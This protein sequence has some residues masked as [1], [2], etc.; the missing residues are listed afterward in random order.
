MDIHGEKVERTEVSLG[1][2]SAKGRGITPWPLLMPLPL[3]TQVR[4]TGILGSSE[5]LEVEHEH[6]EGRRSDDSPQLLRHPLR[7]DPLAH[8][9]PQPQRDGALVNHRLTTAVATLVATLIVS[10]NMFLLY[11]TFFA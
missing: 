6:G 10:L 7:P 2:P 1:N 9:L 3:F 8:F 11:Q 4:G 5:Q